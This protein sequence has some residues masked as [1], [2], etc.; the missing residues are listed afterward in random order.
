V[1]CP[2]KPQHRTYRKDLLATAICPECLRYVFRERE[3]AV[4]VG[5][6]R[7]PFMAADAM[8]DGYGRPHDIG[9]TSK[10]NTVFVHIKC[11][12]AKQKPAIPGPGSLPASS[13]P[14]E[15]QFWKMHTR[16]ALPELEGLVSQHKAGPYRMDFALPGLMLGVELEGLRDHSKT[17]DI[18]RDCLR[19]RW[20]T[21]LG[22]RII[23]IGGREVHHNAEYCVRQVA[24]FA[25]KWA[26]P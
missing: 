8:F 11:L 18:A 4:A 12:E 23:R 19:Q 26:A 17:E 3:D 16:L 15:Q 7:T 21:W 22:W 1:S 13:S 6:E 2:Q 9:W 10:T 25:E 5:G 24:S 20:L 14:I